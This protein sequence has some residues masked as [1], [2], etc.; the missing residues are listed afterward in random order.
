MSGYPN[1][2][3]GVQCHI[4][5]NKWMFEK[6]MLKDDKVTK[7]CSRKSGQMDGQRVIPVHPLPPPP[8]EG[9]TITGQ[10]S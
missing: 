9:C 2:I 10:V 3:T 8:F 5:G 6:N 4:M 1:K 7:L